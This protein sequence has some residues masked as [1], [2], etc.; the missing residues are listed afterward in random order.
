MPTG[1]GTSKHTINVQGTLAL[2]RQVSGPKSLF[3]TQ[4]FAISDV[5]SVDP[6]I[7]EESRLTSLEDCHP[8]DEIGP[9]Q[10]KGVMNLYGS[11]ATVGWR[12]QAADGRGGAG[13]NVTT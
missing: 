5:L 10:S 2:S 11:N 13:T 12:G 1:P 7:G 8:F 4:E 6:P 3:I 9:L